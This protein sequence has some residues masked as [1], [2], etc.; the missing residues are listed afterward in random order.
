MKEEALATFNQALQKLTQ[1]TETFAATLPALVPSGDINMHALR[2][3]ILAHTLVHMAF[4]HLNINFATSDTAANVRCVEAATAM[5]TLFNDIDL[6]RLEI[7]PP[8][9]A[10]ST[11]A[12][13]TE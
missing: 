5:I 8:V 2:N 12:P 13:L 9:I 4:I 3:Q 1:V 11:D 10:V 7:L 6:I